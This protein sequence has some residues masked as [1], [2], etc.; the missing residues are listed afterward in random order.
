MGNLMTTTVEAPPPDARPSLP[1]C[2]SFSSLSTYA[3]CPL[4]YH[5]AYVERIPCPERPRAPLAF[6]SMA[7]AAFEAF[8][9]E[10]R[11]RATRGDPAPGREDLER[12]FRARW[13]PDE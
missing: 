5:F 2:F 1:P 12:L 3:A 11:D 13:D 7:H 4:R 10:R 6:G 8:T 9:L